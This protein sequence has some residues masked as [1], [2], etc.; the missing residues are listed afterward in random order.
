MGD[1][2]LNVREVAQILGMHPEVV[3]LKT[4]R[5]ELPGRQFG[6]RTSPYKYPESKIMAI[7]RSI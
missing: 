5:G 1:R 2:L 4:R 3:R 6:G 7:V